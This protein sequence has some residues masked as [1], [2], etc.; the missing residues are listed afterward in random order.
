MCLKLEKISI[1]VLFY[2]SIRK[3]FFFSEFYFKN[4]V[5][6]NNFI[7]NDQIGKKYILS[8]G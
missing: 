3:W 8:S 1:F 4:Q 5:F 7:K 6:K 2:T